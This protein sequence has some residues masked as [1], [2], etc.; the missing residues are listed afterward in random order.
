MVQMKLSII[1]PV[2][3]EERTIE[4]I[5]KKVVDVKLPIKKEIVLVNDG[6]KDNSKKLIEDFI[7]KN[8][9]VDIKLI[10]KAN[11]GKGSAIRLGFKSATGDIF[12]IQ[13]ADLEYDP[14]DY[15]IMLPPIL[16][17]ECKV[18]YGSRYKSEFGH[19]KENNHMVF[20]IHKLGNNMLSWLTS[21]LY[22]QR[23]TD[24]ETCYKMFT[25]EVYQGL[26]LVSDKFDIEPEI[27]SKILKGGHKV[28]EVPIHYYSRDFSEG[29]KITWKDG[30]KAV[31]TLLKWRFKR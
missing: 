5:L 4:P 8:K 7:K 20:R 25:K 15:S 21:A 22:L 13:D 6:S 19:L 17:N 9:D 14:Q 26:N 28:K 12:I 10:D 1:I 24:M 27:T 30:V 3:N 11:G 29:K 23:I 16:N 18:V 2:Y 31:F